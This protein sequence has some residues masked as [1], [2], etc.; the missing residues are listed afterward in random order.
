[1]YELIFKFIGGQRIGDTLT[2]KANDLNTSESTSLP[3][4]GEDEAISIELCLPS[5][6]NCQ[7]LTVY[8]VN[9]PYTEEILSQDG[10]SIT[11]RWHPKYSF[12]RAEPLFMNYFGMT[13]VY[14]EVEDS[15]GQSHII[16]FPEF[17]VLA[18][19]LSAQRVDDMLT[20]LSSLSDEY[21]L[22]AFHVTKK[23]GGIDK[24]H[25]QPEILI[26]KIE[27]ITNIIEQ[28][29]PIICRS[30]ITKLNTN[31]KVRQTTSDDCLD[32][33]AISWLCANLSVLEPTDN[34]VDTVIKHNGVNYK[35]PI[36]EMQVLEEDTDIYENHVIHGFI[37][38]LN[39][40]IE[41][42]I[43]GYIQF[44]KTC[45]EKSQYKGS[46]Y[47]SFFNVMTKF[48]SFIIEPK[49]KRCFTISEKL[50]RIKYYLNKLVPVS[51]YVRTT[52]YVTPKVR[53]NRSYFDLF[54]QINLWNEHLKPNW[55]LYDNLLGIKSI[56]TLFEY[57][58]YCRV[59]DSLIE[60]FPPENRL[61]E[62]FS[63]NDVNGITVRLIKEPD[64]WT[65]EHK[66]SED[67]DFVN[68][69]GWTKAKNKSKELRKRGQKGAFSRR[70]PDIVIELTKPNGM[71]QLIVMDA[72]YTY[73][74][75]AFTD[76][77]P[78]LTMKYVHGI[79]NTQTGESAV[80]SL[81]IIYPDNNANIQS[82]HHN[83]YAHDGIMP[84]KPALQ[85]ISLVPN[86]ESND[87]LQYL[88]NSLLT[89][90]G[91][92]ITTSNVIQLAS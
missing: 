32:D 52:P 89:I 46:Y 22:S 87:D 29:I 66:N 27:N 2:L 13:Q 21:L 14:T 6:L 57:Y 54:Y 24:G 72:K 19:K 43:N 73:K 68:S 18:S 33:R 61:P 41:E 67:A 12:G 48:K 17:E 8:D 84:T 64:Y 86:N 69:E 55:Q 80:D 91:I 75:K 26:E 77:L 60:I 36:I 9:I 83:N 39:S 81:T 92:E 51:R 90:S 88:I 34:F 31:Y 35:A 5:T 40:Y 53:S 16:R 42:L 85:T 28:I 63:F 11:Y 79:H 44:G 10:L 30:P 15:N 7:N 23:S 4:I 82:F 59:A 25:E 78:Q 58:T 37:E 56:P 62:N 3:F 70:S 76:Y 47:C 65:V 20:Y 45:A 1:M 50:Q 38:N 71:K 74:V 49:L